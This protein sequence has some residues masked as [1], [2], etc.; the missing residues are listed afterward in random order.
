MLIVDFSL[1]TIDFGFERLVFAHFAFQK[2]AGERQLLTETLWCQHIDIA[3]LVLGLAEVVYLDPALVDQGLQTVVE[4]TCAQ[5]QLLSDFTLGHVWVV[6]QQ[7]Q[8]PKVSVFLELRAA[9]GHDGWFGNA[10]AYECSLTHGVSTNEVSER[11][12]ELG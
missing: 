12:Y 4:T 11:L 9:T 10:T 8:H 6:L 2:S 5:T 7:A 3:K 1:Q